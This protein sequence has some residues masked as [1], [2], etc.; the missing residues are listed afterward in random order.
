[1]MVSDFDA[2]HM[3]DKSSAQ[4]RRGRRTV[5]RGLLYPIRQTK[6]QGNPP[7]LSDEAN[8]GITSTRLLKRNERYARM[9]FE[10]ELDQNFESCYIIKVQAPKTLHIVTSD[11]SE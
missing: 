9:S 2:C 11:T 8:L 6:V 4:S 3:T 10:L 1:M 5:I 7:S